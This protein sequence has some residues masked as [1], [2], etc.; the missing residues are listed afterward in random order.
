MNIL[1]WACVRA[2][3][4]AGLHGGQCSDGGR[5][6][7]QCPVQVRTHIRTC[8]CTCTC[9]H[10]HTQVQVQVTVCITTACIIMVA[11]SIPLTA[12]LYC[13]CLATCIPI[14]A[15][16][17]MHAALPIRRSAVSC[18]MH[19]YFT[20]SFSMQ[21]CVRYGLHRP[22]H[23]ARAAARMQRSQLLLER[24]LG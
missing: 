11:H 24:N 21:V 18:R 5:D 23:M 16:Q 17:G 3:L 9:A 20:H 8:T 1:I 13:T 15:H 12:V 4:P 10:T 22:R 19:G 14:Y 7:W 2:C 6:R